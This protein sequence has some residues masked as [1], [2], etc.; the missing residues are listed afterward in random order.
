MREFIGFHAQVTRNKQTRTSTVDIV[1]LAKVM[2]KVKTQ[3]I[4]ISL[5]NIVGC[6]FENS[7]IGQTGGQI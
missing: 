4:V 1:H 2:F 5:L 7:F 6:L 3:K